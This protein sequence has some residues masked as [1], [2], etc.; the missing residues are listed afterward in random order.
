MRNNKE[1]RGIKIEVSKKNNFNK[2]YIFMQVIL[3]GSCLGDLGFYDW[4]KDFKTSYVG[5]LVKK[6]TMA[7]IV[8]ASLN[9]K[10]D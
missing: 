5:Y 9:P 1:W 8:R 3:L 7:Q 6:P 4:G 2:L 10:V